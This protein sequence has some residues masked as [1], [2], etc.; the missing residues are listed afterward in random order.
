M[1]KLSAVI[2]ANLFNGYCIGT[3]QIIHPEYFAESI[4]E[5]YGTFGKILDDGESKNIIELYNTVRL[6]SY[7][8]RQNECSMC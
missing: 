2:V 6:M 8:S 5:N 3:S 7:V 1:E 4:F